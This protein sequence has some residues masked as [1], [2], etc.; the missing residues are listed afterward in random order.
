MRQS[1]EPK[2]TILA[3]PSE[4][5]KTFPSKDQISLKDF[6]KIINVFTVNML[7]EILTTGVSFK[8]PYGIGIIGIKKEKIARRVID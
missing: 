5:Y 4:A 2:P 8:I 3:G 7:N 1:K 6:S